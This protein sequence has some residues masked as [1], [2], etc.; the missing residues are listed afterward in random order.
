[1]RFANRSIAD[2]AHTSLCC[3]LP[4]F[5]LLLSTA[6]MTAV[7][8]RHDTRAVIFGTIASTMILLKAI[9]FNNVVWKSVLL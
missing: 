3:I 7:A 5:F 8:P 6:E 1:M 9:L 2:M 4:R